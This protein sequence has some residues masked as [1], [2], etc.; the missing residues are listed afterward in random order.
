MFPKLFSKEDRKAN[1]AIRAALKAS[2]SAPAS[3][4]SGRPLAR[5]AIEESLEEIKVLST[6]P[7]EV[8]EILRT[9]RGKVGH[10]P[11]GSLTANQMLTIWWRFANQRLRVPAKRMGETTWITPEEAW[12]RGFYVE[13]LEVARFDMKLSSSRCGPFLLVNPNT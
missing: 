11:R 8:L 3:V 2:Y 7:M 1:A 13:V 6:I 5:W 10:G 9:Y 4:P 12:K